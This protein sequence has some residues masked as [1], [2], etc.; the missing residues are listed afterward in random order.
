[1]KLE[2][3]KKARKRR[4]G[5]KEDKETQE[6]EKLRKKAFIVVELVAQAKNVDDRRIER[7]IKETLKCDWLKE[8]EKVRTTY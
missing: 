8:V 5:K 6:G 7:D 2:S 1:M 4:M 3:R